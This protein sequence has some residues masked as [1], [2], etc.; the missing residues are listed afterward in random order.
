MNLYELRPKENLPKS[1]NPWYPWYDKC[2]GFV[3]RA[4]DE[5]TA[6][7]IASENTWCEDEEAWLKERYSTCEI[8]TA[9]GK[10]GMIIEDGKAA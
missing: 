8:L 1:D 5:A 9:D 2:F 10:E 3:V 6:R 4:K 7:K